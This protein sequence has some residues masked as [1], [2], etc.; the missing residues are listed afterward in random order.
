MQMITVSLVAIAF[1]GLFVLATEIRK[2]HKQDRKTSRDVI[3]DLEQ[4]IRL[5]QDGYH[6]EWESRGRH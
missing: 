4:R 1:I 2:R 6:R 5:R 3:L